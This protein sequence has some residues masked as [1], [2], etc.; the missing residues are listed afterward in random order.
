MKKIIILM[1]LILFISINLCTAQFVM[2]VVANKNIISKDEEIEINIELS[3]VNVATFSL[4]IYWD[5]T[6]L[7]YIKGPENSNK[8][9]DRVLYTWVSDNGQNISEIKIGSFKFKGLENGETNL[10]VTGEFY[11]SEGEKVEISDSNIE[12]Q[13]SEPEEKII[14]NKN[15][16]GC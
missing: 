16:N 11:N 5:N 2:K 10:V 1:I 8:V 7:E 14:E 15:L 3:N 13:I 6:K 4:E 12:I 9:N